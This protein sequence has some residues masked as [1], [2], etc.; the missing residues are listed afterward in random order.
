MFELR[1]GHGHVQVLRTR[2]IRRDERQIDVRRCGR[3]ELDLRFLRRLF[4]TLQS[5]LVLGQ[6]DALIFAELVDDPVDQALID[7][8]AAEMRVAVGRLDLDYALADLQD[9]DVERAAAEI[10]D[11]DRLILLLVQ[12]IGQRRGGRLVDQSLNFQAGNLACIFCRLA[13]RV[14]EIRRHGNDC[15]LHLLA[16][17][18]FSGLFQ[19]LQNHR[20][21]FGGRIELPRH[22]DAHIAVRGLDHLV[23]H[24]LHLFGNFLVLAAHEPLDGEDGIFRIGHGLPLRHLPDKTLTALGERHDGGCQ[25]ASF[26]VD[27]DLRLVPFH[28]CDDGIGRAEVNADY[29]S[30]KYFSLLDLSQYMS[31]I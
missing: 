14:I 15:P 17:I 29:L 31:A 11:G 8:V 26:G 27:D 25:P 3:G 1:A 9:R 30:H 21:D 24:H 12:T 2:L 16:E 19:F 20:G 7:V 5:H 13:L 22:L 18:V 4:Q 10:V 28:H 6:I 23:R